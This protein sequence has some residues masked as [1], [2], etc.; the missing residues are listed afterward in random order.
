MGESAHVAAINVYE[1]MFAEDP[2][3]REAWRKYRYEF[4]ELGSSQDGAT[5][6]ERLLGGPLKVDVIVNRL[7]K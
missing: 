7:G 5:V 4:L 6:L 2:F 3:S 1:K